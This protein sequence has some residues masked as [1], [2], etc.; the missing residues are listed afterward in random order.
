MDRD[1]F[2]DLTKA[3]ATRESRRGALKRIGATLMSGA[4]ATFGLGKSLASAQGGP[5]G[6]LGCRCRTGTFESC[7]PGL[8]CCPDDPNLPGGPGTCVAPSACFGGVCSADGVVCPA[9][10]AWDG[11]CIGCCSGHCGRDGLCSSGG[12][13]TAGCDC[14]TGT[15]APCDEGL[16]CCPTIA[17]LLGGPGICLPRTMCN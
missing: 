14:I 11:S 8:V 15:L 16:A 12:C 13:R 1:R 17:G 10:C 6:D 9:S 5:C 3:L 7:V 4:L 2:D